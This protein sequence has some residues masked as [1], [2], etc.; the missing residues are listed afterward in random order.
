M[1]SG[2]PAMALWL[3]ATFTVSIWT[4]GTCWMSDQMSREV[5]ISVNSS[6]EKFWPVSTLRGS[7]SGVSLVTV[8]VSCTEESLSCMSICV[9]WPTDTITF[10]R[11]TVVKPGIVTVTEY[12]P[13][14]TFRN[15]KSPVA[16]T[17]VVVGWEGPVS[18]AVPPGIGVP[19]WSI[20]L[21]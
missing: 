6:R 8:T 3:P 7:S 2:P 19:V 21:P 20:T 18:V 14:G 17:L 5:G 12:L 1:K 11:V 13:G 16:S 9:F 10:S 15:R 4:P